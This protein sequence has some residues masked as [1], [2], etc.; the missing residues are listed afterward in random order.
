MIQSV[1]PN[2]SVPTTATTEAINLEAIL[3]A[4]SQKIQQSNVTIR[5]YLTEVTAEVGSGTIVD[6]DSSFYYILTNHHVLASIPTSIRKCVIT[7]DSIESDFEVIHTDPSKDL[8]YLKI[9]KEGREYLTPLPMSQL[10][11]VL[12]QFVIAVGNPAGAAGSV[13]IGA[14]LAFTQL[15]LINQVA[16][17]H[18][19]VLAHGSSGGALVDLYGNLLGI[20]TWGSNNTFYAIPLST[21]Q[22]FIQSIPIEGE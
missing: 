6:V 4:T 15:D 8:A 16:I 5:I 11:A 9:S 20:N 10:P 2:T 1:P 17:R 14:I 18:T 13:T 19:A 12:D 7:E 3:M 21:I 22:S